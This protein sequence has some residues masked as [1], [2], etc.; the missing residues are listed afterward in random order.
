METESR[1]PGPVEATKIDVARQMNFVDS[2]LGLFSEDLRWQ[3][4]VSPSPATKE[5]VIALSHRPGSYTQSGSG[6]ESYGID[7]DYNYTARFKKY[8]QGTYSIL[9]KVDCFSSSFLK[10]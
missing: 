4:I 8:C 9:K 5:L 3:Y 10:I 7:Y 1:P 2:G 6:H